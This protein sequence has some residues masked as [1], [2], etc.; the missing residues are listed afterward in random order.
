VSIAAKYAL[1]AVTSFALIMAMVEVIRR[2]NVT[3]FLFGMRP[4]PAKAR[5]GVSQVR[6]AGA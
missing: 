4:L 5:A 6:A 3:R 2:F 1:I